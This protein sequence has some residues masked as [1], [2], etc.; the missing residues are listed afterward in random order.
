MIADCNTPSES[1]SRLLHA[2]RKADPE[3]VSDRFPDFIQQ[4]GVM[5]T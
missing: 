2:F 5:N 1:I 3:L 4:P